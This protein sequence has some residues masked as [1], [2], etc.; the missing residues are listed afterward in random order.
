MWRAWVRSSR[1]S[2]HKSQHP[3]FPS[4]TSMTA[5]LSSPEKYKKYSRSISS[6]VSQNPKTSSTPLP[7]S[8]WIW[9]P[10]TSSGKSLGKCDTFP[11]TTWMA[12][13]KSI[14]G[15]FTSLKSGKTLSPNL[16]TV[17]VL[18]SHLRLFLS[19]SSS[20]HSVLTGS[21]ASLCLV[22]MASQSTRSE[23]TKSLKNK[24]GPE[25][26]GDASTKTTNGIKIVAWNSSPKL[27]KCKKH[28]WLICWYSIQKFI[29]LN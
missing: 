16:P 5:H 8:V 9:T 24:Y 23:S 28:D 13:I 26:P 15:K 6:P 29:L 12:P 4:K 3:P 11:F 20:L 10:T 14:W 18:L 7:S 27:A 21:R 25:F 2:R 1:N 22:S 17:T 19:V